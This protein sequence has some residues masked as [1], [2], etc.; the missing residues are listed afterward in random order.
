MSGALRPDV[1]SNVNDSLDS[2][3]NMF[4]L[5]SNPFPF[6]IRSNS[7]HPVSRNNEEGF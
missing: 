6:D 4:R 2:M 3:R 7:T 1:F 5:N